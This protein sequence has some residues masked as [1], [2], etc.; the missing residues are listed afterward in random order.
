M[1]VSSSSFC[2]I[3]FHW[4]PWFLRAV[5]CIHV[6]K[7]IVI[8]RLGELQK[9]RWKMWTCFSQE[10]HNTQSL[11]STGQAFFEYSTHTIKYGLLAWQCLHNI[12][13]ILLFPLTHGDLPEPSQQG[14]F[15]PSCMHG[16]LSDTGD[17]CPTVDG[18]FVFGHRSLK[19][20]GVPLY[21][22]N[23]NIKD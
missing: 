17:T 14:V 22:S 1:I 9:M 21:Q 23:G 4:V 15:L 7:L 11:V 3:K 12:Q 8:E 2:W 18:L 20:T 10:S 5:S 19:G 13:T 16:F 6:T